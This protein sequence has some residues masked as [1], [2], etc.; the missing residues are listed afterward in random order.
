VISVDHPVVAG[1]PG[2]ASAVGV[3]T[4]TVAGGAVDVVDELLELELE[5]VVDE[6]AAAPAD[7]DELLEPELARAL[8]VGAEL[9]ELSPSSVAVSVVPAG[10]PAIRSACMT[11]IALTTST[12][13]QKVNPPV[14]DAVEEI[15]TPA[16]TTVKAPLAIVLRLSCTAVAEGA[17]PDVMVDPAG[18]TMS[19]S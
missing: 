1:G 11:V 5:L 13:T 9:L 17:L 15:E 4:A 12:S 2:V 3:P 14:V 6:G 19:I 7:V 8:V 18:I 10:V 16:L